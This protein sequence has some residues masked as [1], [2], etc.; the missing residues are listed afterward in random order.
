MYWLSSN[1]FSLCQ[2][3]FMK[4]PAVRE[5]FNI[6]ELVRHDKSWQA[7]KPPILEGFKDSKYELSMS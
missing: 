5:Y 4:I 1:A 7:K 3:L 2:A 6:P